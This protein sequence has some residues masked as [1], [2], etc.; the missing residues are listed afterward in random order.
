MA[1]LP[2]SLKDSNWHHICI[3]W[4][5]RDGLW[6]AYQDGELRGSGENL[7]AWHPIKPHG[8]L[9]LGQEQV[10]LSGVHPQVSTAPT[11]GPLP[12]TREE[13]EQK[14]ASCLTHQ[15]ADGQQI[16]KEQAELKP[17]RRLEPCSGTGEG[18]NLGSEAGALGGSFLGWG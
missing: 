10:R 11:L 14:L 8:I 13:L 4:T 6:S 3:A 9:I 5:T 15:F 18:M 17:G 1:Q 16:A 12:R 2:L 7:A